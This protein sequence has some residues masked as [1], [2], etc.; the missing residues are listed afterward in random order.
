LYLQTPPRVITIVIIITAGK[1]PALTSSNP[2]SWPG[3][4]LTHG[5]V[6][7]CFDPASFQGSI[8]KVL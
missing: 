4:S 8:S 1:Y 3:F 2:A 6:C 7:G 5:V